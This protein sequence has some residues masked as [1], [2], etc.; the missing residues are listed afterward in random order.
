MD[1]FKTVC[2]RLVRRQRFLHGL[3]AARWTLMAT[4][5][6]TAITLILQALKIVPTLSP[7]W[8][9]GGNLALASVA[10]AW[11]WL[12]PVNLTEMLFRADR[13][14][15]TE[16]K[17]VTLYELSLGQA[18]RE[19]LPLLIS[20]LGS[21]T[22]D[23]STALPIGRRERKLWLGVLALGFVCVGMI[24][25]V[26]AGV[27]VWA[28][29]GT[30]EQAVSSQSSESAQA[31]P[32]EMRLADLVQPP[33]PELA[34]KLAA[35]RERFEQAR[36][37]LAQNP[38]DPRARAI[39]QQLQEE[40]RQEQD[41][42]V[43]PPPLGEDH[44]APS[45]KPRDDASLV[46]NPAADV[47]S[48]ENTDSASRQTEL[49]R[50][51]RMLRDIQGQAQELSPEELQKL[52]E[53]LQQENPDAASIAQQALQMG[54]STQ[55]FSERLEE[56]LRNLGARRDLHQ[57][58]EQLQRDV[59]S[60]L[61]QSEQAETARGDAPPSG[62]AQPSSEGPPDPQN[63]STESDSDSAEGPRQENA[64]SQ[65]SG[66]RGKA[67]LDPEAVKDLPDLSQ[68]R[69]HTRSFSVPGT[70]EENLEILFEII[71]TGL[72]QNPNTPGQP[73]PVEID[74]RKVEAL[75]D[76]LEIPN[77]LRDA[78]RQYFLSLARPLP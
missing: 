78:V 12:R 51:M 46:E 74:Y 53:Q 27:F 45:G 49:D 55:E 58:L 19:F 9:L 38:N 43:S 7:L 13:N 77:E 62:D 73:T 2:A 18:P 54:P 48:P 5:A 16:E 47:R 72:P 30:S 21:L 37:A 41:R 60:A 40:I 28:P 66:G 68:L 70:D 44:A 56:A 76:A 50:L 1:S 29:W 71:S 67:P 59:Q 8:L 24:G 61:S 69:E 35:L 33:P 75:I 52:L 32:R 31:P 17:L 15:H 25:V 23:L 10:F 34:Q 3:S 42:L 22:L 11:G 26:H 6:L 20:R 14:A 64:L 63:A 39:L 65:P 57:E 4:L 36:A